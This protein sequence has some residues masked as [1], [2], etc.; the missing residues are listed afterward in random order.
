MKW[1]KESDL[2]LTELIAE[3]KRYE[4]IAVLL[5]RTVRSITSRCCRLKLKIVFFNEAE[6]KQCGTKFFKY[7]KDSKVFCGSSCSA[8]YNNANRRHTEETRTK[9]SKAL[10]SVKFDE[11]RRQKL[12]GENNGNWKGGVSLIVK[13]KRVRKNSEPRKCRFCRV[14]EIIDKRKIICN[15]CKE[16]YYQFYRPLCEF[17]FDIH[18]YKDKFD[19]QLVEKFGWYSPSNKGNNLNG[20][21]KDHMYSVRDGFINKVDPEIISHPANCKFMV[22]TENNKKKVSS[23]ITLEELLER[24]KN[25]N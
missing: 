11:N 10:V 5:N 1:T 2:K 12:K 6:C 14:N 15:Q 20:V 23:S 19:F 18:N 3:G 13:P 8:T 9:I 4:E 16:E 7:T 22:H 17:N 21:S 25:W 24:I